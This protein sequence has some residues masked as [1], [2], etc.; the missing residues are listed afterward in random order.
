MRNAS[1][2]QSKM[3]KASKCRKEM[4]CLEV[5]RAVEVELL[6]THCH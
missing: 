5:C 4:I 3:R 1:G 6:E 2:Y